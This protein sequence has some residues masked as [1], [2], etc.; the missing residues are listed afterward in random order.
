VND[1]LVRVRLIQY[2][3]GRGYRPLEEVSLAYNNT[4]ID[5]V[6][7]RDGVLCGFEIKS[8]AD[9]LVRLKQQA[10]RYRR[11][12]EKLYLVGAEG[13]L[14]G[15]RAVL[16]HYWGIWAVRPSGSGVHIVRKTPPAQ[17]PRANRH[18]KGAPL[19]A[20][21]SKAELLDVLRPIEPEQRLD[22][23]TRT[24]LARLCAERLS[25]REIERCLF[26]A[27]H[28]S[29]AEEGLERVAKD[30]LSTRSSWCVL[31]DVGDERLD[32][33]PRGG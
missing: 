23:L 25:I 9:T 8:E 7:M 28:G 22:E 5:V 21:M 18:Q 3:T 26:D 32:C 19:A 16:P 33:E 2:L 15:A 6:G 27:M 11:Y 30:R 10:R 31:D 4:R 13:H 17:S 14:D 1:K 29:S 24:N 20:L 12:F